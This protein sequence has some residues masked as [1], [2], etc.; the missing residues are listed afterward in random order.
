MIACQ[1]VSMGLFW[2]VFI[3]LKHPL[4]SVITQMPSVNFQKAFQL[5]T[6]NVR[7]SLTKSNFIF[8]SRKLNFSVVMKSIQIRRRQ[9]RWE[10]RGLSCQSNK[11]HSLNRDISFSISICDFFFRTT[12]NVWVLLISCPQQFC[13]W[14]LLSNSFV[15]ILCIW[16]IYF[17]LCDN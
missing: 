10:F 15:F 2:K 6:A 16:N 1:T 5:K 7:H 11:P 9:N 4:C 17:S 13:D 12:L 14:Y 3:K 8:Y